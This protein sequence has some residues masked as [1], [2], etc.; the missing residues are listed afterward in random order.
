MSDADRLAITGLEVFAHHGALH[1]ERTHGQRFVVDVVLR[2]D[3]G[4]AAASDDLADTVDYGALAG[5]IVAV[6][7]GD[8]ADLLETVAGRVADRCLEDGRVRD[9]EVTIHKPSAPLPVIARD[10]AVTLY[11]RRP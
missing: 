8:P 5:D 3:L 1:H 4:S 9:V 6:V 7:A 10:V 11:R 2:L